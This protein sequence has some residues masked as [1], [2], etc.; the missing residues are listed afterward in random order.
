M[1]ADRDVPMDVPEGDAEEQSRSWEGEEQ[2]GERAPTVP[3]DAPEA[4]VLDQ[5]RDAAP[6]DDERERG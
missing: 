6:E 5:S 1:G 2:E 3:I 4:D